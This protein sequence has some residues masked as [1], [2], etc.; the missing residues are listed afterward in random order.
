MRIEPLRGASPTLRSIAAK[1]VWWKTEEQALAD[2]IH[3][4]CR[5]M[6]YGTWNDVV[7]ARAEMGDELWETA[8]RSAPPGLFDVRSWNY[9]NLVFGFV[10]VPPLPTRRFP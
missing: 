8:L 6:T 1:V 9:W 5:I 3:L 7:L 4:A 2:P 10:P